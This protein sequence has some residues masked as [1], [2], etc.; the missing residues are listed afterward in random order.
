M[1]SMV[2]AK[3]P[4][5]FQKG[6]R[7]GGGMLTFLTESVFPHYCKRCG[8]VEVNI[9]ERKKRCPTCSSSR[10]YAYGS[11]RVSPHDNGDRTIAWQEY[12]ASASQHFCPSCKKY[13]LNFEEI[14]SFD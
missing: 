10:V 8:L 7:I 13:H 12:A 9:C 11:S 5:G 1:G 14:G 4:C 2:K 6:V 3:C